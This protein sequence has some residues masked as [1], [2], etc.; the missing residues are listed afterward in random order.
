MEV[1]QENDSII[2]ALTSDMTRLKQEARHIQQDVF[3]QNQLLEKLQDFMQSARDGVV[4]SVGKIDN[5]MGRYGFKHTVVFGVL[6]CLA[7]ILVFYGTKYA[8]ANSGSSTTATADAPTTLPSPP[9][10]IMDTKAPMKDI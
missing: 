7:L 1:E 8:W 3:A 4:G 6:A 2:N 10:S 9:K 5:V